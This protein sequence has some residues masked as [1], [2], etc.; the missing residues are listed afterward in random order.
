MI[1]DRFGP[2]L[3]ANSNQIRESAMCISYYFQKCHGRFHLLADV[4]NIL[5][6]NAFVSLCAFEDS[7]TY[8]VQTNKFLSHSAFRFKYV[9]R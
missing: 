8:P 5:Y 1:D 4:G 7:W 6:I 2:L 9:S 3:F